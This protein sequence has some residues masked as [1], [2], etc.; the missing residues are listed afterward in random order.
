MKAPERLASETRGKCIYVVE[1]DERVARLIRTT[2]T[3]F[4]F[5]PVMFRT[6]AELFRQVSRRVPDLCIVDLGLPDMDGMD[7]VR[8][9][10]SQ[11]GCGILI[12]TGR[13]YV[14]DRIMGL[15]L[16]ADDYVAKPFDA[17]ELVARIRSILRRSRP[18][19]G[20]GAHSPS[21]VAVFA[22]WRFNSG[23]NILTAQ[24]GSESSL[25]TAEAQLLEVFLAH[26]N[27]ILTR[28]QLLCEREVSPLDRSI[29]VRISRLRRKL[30]VDPQNP[31][32]IRT[33]YGAGYLF[34][35]DVQRE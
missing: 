22:G 10:Q 17:R 2:L 35:A 4:C 24:D 31:K 32:L 13:G 1:D 27:R 34:S 26:P 5:E 29:D 18:F 14:G 6:A 11:H 33:V 9:L 21:G 20:M 15:E 8:Q 28:E 7:V 3:D 30:E 19:P 23:N 12:L 16:G 25:S